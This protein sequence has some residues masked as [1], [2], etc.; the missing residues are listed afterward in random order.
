MSKECIYY[1]I[2]KE[3]ICYSMSKECICYRMSKECIYY[4]M[5]KEC[6]YY[7][8]RKESIKYANF[9]MLTPY[10]NSKTT[11]NI[12]CSTKYQLVYKKRWQ[13]WKKFPVDINMSLSVKY[14]RVTGYSQKQLE[15]CYIARVHV[16][17]LTCHY[18][19]RQLL[20]EP[21]TLT[22]ATEGIQTITDYTRNYKRTET[23]SF[24][25]K[26]EKTINKLS[27][28]E[29]KIPFRSD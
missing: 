13:E 10:I 15:V 27:R 4:S 7:S 5:S 2:S 21:K 18:L 29:L 26:L 25:K 19:L 14:E 20:T 9:N 22:S 23:E 28:G 16:I 12:S 24:T 11:A 17:Q 3:C 6:I 8:I 1:R